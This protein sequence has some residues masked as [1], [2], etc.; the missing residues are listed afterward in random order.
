VTGPETITED[1]LAAVLA[2][3]LRNCGGTHL[4]LTDPA[5]S[6]ADIFT[7][8]QRQREPE[9]EPAAAYVDARGD[10]Y[11]RGSTGGW[12]D[13]STTWHPHAFPLRPLRRLVPD[14]PHPPRPDSE[15]HLAVIAE[16]LSRA[17]AARVTGQIMGLLDGTPQQAGT[18]DR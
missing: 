14:S 3:R 17:T 10:I 18:E 11:L 1:E 9:Y 8:A 2:A 5:A 6:A 7:E 12:V 4:I 15:D 16:H 13:Y